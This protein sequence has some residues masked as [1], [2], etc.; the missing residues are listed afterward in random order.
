[1]K[2]LD[3]EAQ[4]TLLAQNFYTIWAHRIYLRDQDRKTMSHIQQVA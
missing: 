4:K 3:F 1:M 2:D